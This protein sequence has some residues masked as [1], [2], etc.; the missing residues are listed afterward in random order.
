MCAYPMR[1]FGAASIWLQHV[2]ERSRPQIFQLVFLL[3]SIP[4]FKISHFF[5]KL[6]YALNQIQLRRLC[7]EDFF[8][9]FYSYPVARGSITGVLKS[10]RNIE[11][12]LKSAQASEHFSDHDFCS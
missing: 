12:S 5:F 8:L 6:A 1:R 4:C 7:R 2:G 9:K 10:L 11:H 3:L